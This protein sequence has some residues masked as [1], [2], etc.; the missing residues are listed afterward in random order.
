MDEGLE[1]ETHAPISKFKSA[2]LKWYLKVAPVKKLSSKSLKR[3]LDLHSSAHSQLLL[4]IP[5]G[6]HAHPLLQVGQPG[7]QYSIQSLS[8][9]PHLAQNKVPLGFMQQSQNQPSSSLVPSKYA[10]P[11]LPLQPR[12]KTPLSDQHQVLRYPTLSGPSASRIL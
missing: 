5:T 11:S 3:S 1:R 7:Q 2:L 10:T 6:Q 4:P 12:F 9:L 8:R